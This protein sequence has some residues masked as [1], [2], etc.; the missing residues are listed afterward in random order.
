MLWDCLGEFYCTL[1]PRYRRHEHSTDQ[2]ITDL[3]NAGLSNAD[4]SKIVQSLCVVAYSKQTVSNITDKWIDD[5]IKS[6]QVE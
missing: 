1:L 4:I 5:R 3:F 2:T 6:E